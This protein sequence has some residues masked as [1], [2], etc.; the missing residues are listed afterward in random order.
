MAGRCLLCAASL[1]GANG[2]CDDCRS[3]LPPLPHHCERCAAPMPP[4]SPALCGQCHT[5]PPAFDS[6]T[7]AFTYA[8]PVDRLVLD[9]KFGAK[10]D[11]APLLAESLA[12]A[13]R[14]SA[15][16]M[17]ELLLPIPLHPRRLRERGFNQA[18]EI[19]RPLAR[20]LDLPLQK[21]LL[22]RVRDT[23]TQ[24]L[25]SRKQRRVNLRRAFQC[26]TPPGV[27]HIALIDDVMTTGTTASV[28]AA[29]LKARGVARVD[30]WVVAR[31]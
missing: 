5:A 3:D 9:L 28:A 30:I 7:V 14:S 17:P 13:I 11:R 26:H 27:K 18:L 16:P 21:D 23:A 25:L 1:A 4:G 10:L 31:A 29:C 19:A 20:A 2:L 22:L 24:S 15:T 12:N 8:A 6:V